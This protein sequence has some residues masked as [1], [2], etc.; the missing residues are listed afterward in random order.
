MKKGVIYG[1][2]LVFG[3]REKC[4][5]CEE[6]E[7]IGVKVGVKYIK[8]SICRKILDG[9]HNVEKKHVT[10]LLKFPRILSRNMSVAMR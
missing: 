9:D 3:S 2:Y 8:A 7:K 5:F 10:S 6:N 1:S 4:R